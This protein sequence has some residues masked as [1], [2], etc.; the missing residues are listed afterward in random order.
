MSNSCAVMDRPLSKHL[1]RRQL[2][3]IS[4]RSQ[5]LKYSKHGRFQTLQVCNLIPASGDSSSGFSDSKSGIL[6]PEFACLGLSG[7]AS[8]FPAQVSWA[9]VPN[10][11]KM[12]KDERA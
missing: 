3:Y 4:A 2:S 10:G 9:G 5:K 7:Y 6:A 8:R 12:A 11:R 1:P